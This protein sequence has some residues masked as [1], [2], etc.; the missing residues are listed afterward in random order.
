VLQSSTSVPTRRRPWWAGGAVAALLLAAATC[1][2]ADPSDPLSYVPGDAAVFIHLRAGEVWNTPLVTEIRKAVGGDL[3]KALA[4]AEKEIG[5]R[6]DLVDTATFFYPT[7]PQGP[8]DETTFV[9]IVTTTKPYDKSA[10]LKNVRA[11]DAK[12]KDGFIPLEAKLQLALVGERTFAVM[13][14]SLVEKFKKGDFGGQKDGVMAE[15]LKLAAAKHQFVFSIDF[16]KLPNELFTA[17]PAE[18]QP[19]LPLLKTKSSVLFADL[20]GKELKAGMNFNC[21]DGNAAQ[22]AERSFKLLMKL[23]ADGLADV[24]KDEKLAKEL[25]VALPALKEL[26]RAVND[27]KVVRN[28]ARLETS[29][30]LKADFPVEKVVAELAKKI[31]EGNAQAL[32]TNNLKQIGIAMHNY[33]D[34]HQGFP[35][36]SI[37]DR[38]GKPLLSWRVAILPYVEQDQ[39]YKRFKLD[40]PW[41][42]EHNKKLIAEMPKLYA[43]PGGKADGKTHYKVFYGNNAVFDLVQATKITE[44]PDG[45]SNTL[46]V[47]EAAEGTDWTK[48]ED[49]EYDP[50]LPV[51][52]LLLFK[53]DKTP[54]VFC[55]GSV[56][57]LKKGLA[58]KTWHMLIQKNDGQVIPDLDE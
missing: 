25:A 52:K 49:I 50:K 23:A 41:D 56:R 46:M 12:E 38:K 27:V 36:T 37:C 28:D 33:H 39:L 9:A 21:A 13:H 43:L 48:P 47:V 32:A 54:V 30:T 1:P 3:D 16:S 18:L 4:A 26:E 35:S 55:D 6:P 53:D 8:G 5:I 31:T 40:E 58:D 24:L 10:L 17:A 44:I 45:T 42:S 51:G 7:M 14:E 15:A 57:F 20:K 34:V 22:D 11:K 19:F 2:A 29:L